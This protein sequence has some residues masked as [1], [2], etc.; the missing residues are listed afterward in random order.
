MSLFDFAFNNGVL[1]PEGTCEW[2][3]DASSVPQ[4]LSVGEIRVHVHGLL[5]RRVA[6]HWGYITSILSLTRDYRG[7]A[8]VA[9]TEM[10]L[11]SA[12][13]ALSLGLFLAT[14]V[15]QVS[16]VYVSNL[17]PICM[18][19]LCHAASSC[20]LT[21]GCVDGYCGPFQLSRGYWRD[22][23]L[24]VLPDD[25]PSRD[26][27]FLDCAQDYSC[28]Q[29]IVEEYIIRFGSR[30]V[31]TVNTQKPQHWLH[32]VNAS[33]SR[34]MFPPSVTLDWLQDVN[35]SRSR[36]MFP[37]SATLDW[38]QDVNASRSREMFPPSATLDWLQDAGVPALD[39]VIV[40][41]HFKCINFNHLTRKKAVQ[42]LK[43]LL[44]AQKTI[45]DVNIRNNMADYRPPPIFLTERINF[46]NNGRAD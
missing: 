25:N 19:C 5:W 1:Q 11:Q 20:N 23:G 3:V 41:H 2:P 24:H 21:L 32:D 22:A 6:V 40:H 8:T 36:E 12:V 10:L 42:L 35:A 28:A 43:K 18:R 29:R 34:E 39:E 14:V 46:E 13:G 17:T 37:P 15:L 31:P 33:R 45:L 4:F 30:N 44:S 26:G 38:L 16:S 9:A 7:S 27:A